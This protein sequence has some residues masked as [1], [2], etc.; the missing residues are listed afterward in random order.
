M[1]GE[2]VRWPVP[3]WTGGQH[4]GQ[5]RSGDTPTLPPPSGPATA[6]HVLQHH[7]SAHVPA[8]V[9]THTVLPPGLLLFPWGLVPGGPGQLCPG[10]RSCLPLAAPAPSPPVLPTWAS[11]GPHGRAQRSLEELEDGG[12]PSVTPRPPGHHRAPTSP[13]GL[14]SAPQHAGSHPPCAQ[15][16]AAAPTTR[17][18][19]A[20]GT[21]R[22]PLALPAAPPAPAVGSVSSEEGAVGSE[23][24]GG[25]LMLGDPSGSV[26]HFPPLALCSARSATA[27]SPGDDPVPSVQPLLLLVPLPGQLHS[28]GSK[29][30]SSETPSPG[31]T[32]SGQPRPPLPHTPLPPEVAETSF[33]LSPLSQREAP[34]F[35]LC[36]CTWG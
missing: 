5:R 26:P 24:H 15:A 1:S 7:G 4:E 3:A 35:M 28:L 27:P 21:P 16:L 23:L 25:S 33:C 14:V 31:L 11:P 8:H 2:A 19:V 9:P 32:S 18:L 10:P 20:V 36:P 22:R 12:T 30:T 17:R 13:A 29:V 6:R 34:L